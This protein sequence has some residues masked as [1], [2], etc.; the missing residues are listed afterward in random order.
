MNEKTMTVTEHLSELRG[1]IIV[2]AV[3][4][5]VVS[6]AAFSF[7]GP[8]SDFI[9]APAKGLKFVYLSPPELFITYV[10]LSFLVSFIAILPLLLFELW[11]YIRP[12][13]NG[14]LSGDGEKQKRSIVRAICFGALFFLVGASFAFYVVVPLTIRFFISYSSPKIEAMFSIKEYFGFVSNL[15]LSFGAVFEMPILVA[16]LG[17]LGIIESSLL[18]RFRRYAIVIA[19]VIAALISPP[20]IVSQTILAMPMLGLYEL[21][22]AVLRVQEKRR[23][24]LELAGG[25]A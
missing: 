3:A 6:S 13:L 21:S 10:K 5:L 9:M 16:I 12:A 20:E 23:S 18:G 24:R 4:F 15:V 8:I 11:A 25:I 22:Y 19:F 17:S 14:R 7:A 2:C 1:R